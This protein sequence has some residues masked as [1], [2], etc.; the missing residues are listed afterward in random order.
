MKKLLYITGLIIVISLNAFSTDNQP[1]Y[2]YSIS[3]VKITGGPFLRAQQTALNYI[4]ALDPD[5]LLAPFLKDA[6]IESIADNYPNW[7][8]MGLD[9]HIGGH[10]LSAMALMYASTGNEELLRRIGYMTS[11]LKKCQ[12][13]NGNGYVGGIPGGQ[14][15]WAEIAAGK[16][17]AGSFSLNQKWV[18]LYNIHK[19]FNGLV[20]VTRNTH[21]KTAAEVLLK[22]SEWMY[23]L[24]S[25]LSDEQIQ[26]MLRSEHGGLNE[27][28]VD[29]AEISGDAK[30]LAMAQRLS[31]RAILDPLL[32][33]E[34]RLTG[35]HANTQIPKVVGYKKYADAAK[36]TEWDNAASFF[37]NTVIDDWT[38]SIGG[39]SVREHFH[40]ANDFSDMISSNQGPET[41]NTYNM[42]RLT[43]LLCLSHPEKKYL[44]YYER[45]LFNHILSSEHPTKGGFVYFTPMRPRH[46]RVYSQ[47]QSGFWCC[48]GSGLENP[49]KYAEMIYAHDYEDIYI[50]LFIESELSWKEKGI[51]LIQNTNF[52]YEEKTKIIVNPEKMRKF[53][54]HIRRPDWV[55]NSAFSISINGKSLMVTEMNGAYIVLNRKWKKGDVV[56][57]TLPMQNRVEFMPDDSPWVS[58]MHGPIVLAAVTDSTDLGGLWADDSRMGHVAGDKL[59]PIDEAPFLLANSREGLASFLQETGPMQFSIDSLLY[60]NKFDG[61]H[62]VPFYTVH[63]ARYMIYWRL[64]NESELEVRLEELRKQEAAL[65][66]L[67]Q[68]T[69]DY[70]ATG[71]QQPETE[72]NFRG[73]GTE[74]GMYEGRYWRH[75]WG[76]FSYDL[77]NKGGEGK[78]LRI[79]Y[80]GA[81]KG[82]TFKILV[83]GELLEQVTSKGHPDTFFTVD[84]LIPENLRT[85][86][87]NIKFEAMEKSMAGGVFEIRLLR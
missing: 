43:K 78:V 41:C 20:D 40:Q 69:V 9:G 7:E 60:G 87:I 66:A 84:Y 73:E 25:G 11:W 83:N 26:D 29:V 70:V 54:I 2:P 63:E 61:L 49:G 55:E 14:A 37:W 17:D 52:P 85:E 35:L 19:L 3:S 34:N 81:D 32:A 77:D 86:T 57:V 62:L 45:A 67:E 5:R 16:I 18:P 72:H 56:E 48:V 51:S 79:M 80:S 15:M 44:E 1:L 30:Y 46:Y 6:G 58:F 28:F 74:S 39:N 53:G 33:H 65:L 47:P 24:L 13:K 76:W 36:N 59:Y 23:Q 38:V 82:R 64:Y 22:L 31:H 68:Q 10:Y 8:S 12:D 75:A 50:N 71:E 27:V 4:L 42:L 21:D